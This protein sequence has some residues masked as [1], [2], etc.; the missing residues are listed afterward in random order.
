VLNSIRLVVQDNPEGPTRLVHAFI[1]VTEQVGEDMQRGYVTRARVIS[2]PDLLQQAR[3]DA[4]VYL[5]A[6]KKRF[7]EFDELGG[8][9]DA[10]LQSVQQLQ[11]PQAEATA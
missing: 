6:G 3:R 8:I 10:A 9:F 2:T 11:Q 1:S 4:A 7:A 5:A